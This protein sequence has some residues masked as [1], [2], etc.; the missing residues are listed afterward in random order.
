MAGQHFDDFRSYSS[1]N[2]RPLA[3]RLSE[4]Y[5]N[6]ERNHVFWIAKELNIYPDGVPYKKSKTVEMTKTGR[7]NRENTEYVTKGKINEKGIQAIEAYLVREGYIINKSNGEKKMMESKSIW[8]QADLIAMMK[9]DY[10]KAVAECNEAKTEA[11]QYCELAEKYEKEVEELKDKL[12]ISEKENTDLKSE[13]QELGKMQ[14]KN[15]NFNKEIDNLQVRIGKY[16]QEINM[17]LSDMSV[18]RKEY[19]VL[20]T[21][22]NQMQDNKKKLDGVLSD[23]VLCSKRLMNLK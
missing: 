3:E 22:V 1:N 13:K 2:I 7:I 14:L 16:N 9:K 21:K 12:L 5:I 17:L 4:K 18:L 15:I 20:Q 11:E 10:E 8:E 6:L 19:S 23:L